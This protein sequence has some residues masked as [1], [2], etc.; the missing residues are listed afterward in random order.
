MIEA[1][2]LKI[3]TKYPSP[4]ATV[5]DQL[6]REIELRSGVL[7]PRLVDALRDFRASKA[8]L[9]MDSTAPNDPVPMYAVPLHASRD[10]GA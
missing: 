4:S 6:A 5:V 10:E 9:T 2:V 3:A 8:T 7:D 1:L